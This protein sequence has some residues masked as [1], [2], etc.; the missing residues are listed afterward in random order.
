MFPVPCKNVKCCG[1]YTLSAEVKNEGDEAPRQVL[2][3]LKSVVARTSLQGATTMTVVELSYINVSKEC[4]IECMYVFPLESTTILADFSATI[5]DKTVRTK[6]TE[7]GQA[8]QK[9]DDVIAVMTQ[10]QTKKQE[11]MTIKIG[12]L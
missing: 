7:K 8:E 4:A 3:P 1:R 9:D 12:S 11:Y 6:V 5:G 2:V 10:K